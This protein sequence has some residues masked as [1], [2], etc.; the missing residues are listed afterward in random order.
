MTAARCARSSVSR[1][2][3]TERVRGLAYLGGPDRGR[4]R[5]QVQQQDAHVNG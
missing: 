3:G 1:I 4:G 5:V 2:P